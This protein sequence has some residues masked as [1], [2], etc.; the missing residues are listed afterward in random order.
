MQR[1]LSPAV[2]VTKFAMVYMCRLWV[3]HDHQHDQ[4]VRMRANAAVDLCVHF[5][6]AVDDRW[7][8]GS[9]SEVQERERATRPEGR[10]KGEAK[11]RRVD[12]ENARAWNRS[13][14]D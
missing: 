2:S 11:E 14:G 10:A 12:G 4:E 6:K 13:I 3:S 5:L 8:C 7:L 9:A 1:D